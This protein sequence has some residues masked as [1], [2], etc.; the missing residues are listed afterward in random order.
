MAAGE[1]VVG[2]ERPSR[3]RCPLGLVTQRI[4]QI[5]P[6]F[7]ADR[8]SLCEGHDRDLKVQRLRDDGD[9]ERDFTTGLDR[10][11]LIGSA[12]DAYD[13]AL[14]KSLIGLFKTE[15]LRPAPL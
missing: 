1:N 2:V 11:P 5:C 13:N 8:Q 4:P 9:H 3:A 6:G 12:G 10:A 7:I 15:C 14:M